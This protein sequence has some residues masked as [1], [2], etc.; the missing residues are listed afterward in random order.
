MHRMQIRQVGVMAPERWDRLLRTAAKEFAQAG[1]ERASLN[2]II[3]ECGMSK[4]SFYHYVD[5]KEQLFEHVLRTYGPALI[6]ALTLPNEAELGRDF[7]AEIDGIAARLL[8]LSARDPIYGLIGRMCYLPDAPSGDATALGHG[9][10]LVLAWLQRAIEVGR[11]DGAVRDDLPAELQARALLA[12]VR[13]FDEWSLTQ[14]P[15]DIETQQRLVKAQ[16]AAI[17]RLIGSDESR[18]D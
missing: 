8:E 6:E 14:M 18:L 4:S 11:R 13:V 12:V 2:R 10:A 15:P 5:S 3:G 1:Y 17:R 9:F 7:W 16:L